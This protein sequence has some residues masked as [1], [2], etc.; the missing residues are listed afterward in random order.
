MKKIVSILSLVAVTTLLH[1]QGTVLFNA[2]GIVS[3]N[4]A[5]TH[6][7]G[8]LEVGQ[9]VPTPV[10]GNDEIAIVTF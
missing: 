9:T 1:A 4:T 8:G 2:N 7:A 5:I 10:S 3:T 6:F